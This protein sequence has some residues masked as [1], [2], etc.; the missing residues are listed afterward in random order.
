MLERESA[1]QRQ[2][3]NALLG[4]ARARARDRQERVRGI[5]QW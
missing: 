3:R 1:F 4:D 2:R 5:A